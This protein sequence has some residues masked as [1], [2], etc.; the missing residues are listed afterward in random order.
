MYVG[1][2]CTVVEGKI[3]KT[4]THTNAHFYTEKLVRIRTRG[5]KEHGV[6]YLLGGTGSLDVWHTSGANDRAWLACK[7]IRVAFLSL[8]YN[9]VF[10][11]VF[12]EKRLSTWRVMRPCACGPISSYCYDFIFPD[13]PIFNIAYTTYRVTRIGGYCESA[14]TLFAPE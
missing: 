11:R 1:S 13:D 10:V 12:R 8:L 14:K 7:H 9:I 4:H 5:S 3:L 6:Y 2:T